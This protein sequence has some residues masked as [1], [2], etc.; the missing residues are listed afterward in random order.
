MAPLA[1]LLAAPLLAAP[2]LVMT[3]A[4][5]GESCE[6]LHTY[7]STAANIALW[8]IYTKHQHVACF[9]ASCVDITRQADQMP[10]ALPSLCSG[11]GTDGNLPTPDGNLPTPEG[12]PGASTSGDAAP[13]PVPADG[14]TGSTVPSPPSGRPGAS[15][16]I[17][18]Y[19]G[20]PGGSTG[21]VTGGS[22]GSTG[23]STGGADGG[24]GGNDGCQE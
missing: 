22:S 2:P 3:T 1:A 10:M 6:S 4:A 11:S 21:G 19:G 5:P 18:C 13:G 8:P 23:G 9:G 16:P 14:N 24:N 7:H 15:P 17:G 12:N 20:A